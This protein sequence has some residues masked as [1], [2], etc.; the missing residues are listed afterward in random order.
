MSEIDRL[1]E[2]LIALR[3]KG[4]AAELDG[5]LKRAGEKNLGFLS[6]FTTLADIELQMRRQNAISLRWRQSK[7]D[8]KLTIDQFDFGHHKSRKDQKQCILNLMSLDF[9]A[10]HVDMIL[11]GN[12][13]TGKIPG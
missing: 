7:L 12:P 11:I 2:K 9:I 10:Q 3:L 6:T 13:G 8:E 5:V 4:M 1:K